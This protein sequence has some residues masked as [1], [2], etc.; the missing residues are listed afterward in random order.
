MTKI[1]LDTNVWL[2]FFLYDNDQFASVEKLITAIEEGKFLPS[3]K[4]TVF[5]KKKWPTI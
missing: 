4:P 2:R 1:F 5:L 3:E